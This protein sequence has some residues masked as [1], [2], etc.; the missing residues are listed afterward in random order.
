MAVSY[1]GGAK[2]EDLTNLPLGQFY[3]IYADD[4][5]PFYF[6]GGYYMAA[7]PDQPDLIVAEYQGGGILR[8][9]MR[10]LEQQDISPAPP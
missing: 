2:W 7:H 10:T 5:R 8:T 9:D 4:R 1:D 3:Q 6:L